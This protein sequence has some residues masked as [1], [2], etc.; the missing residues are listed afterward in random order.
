MSYAKKISNGKYHKEKPRLGLANSSVIMA[1]L[2]CIAVFRNR[3]LDQVNNVILCVVLL[4]I[5]YFLLSSGATF[6]MRAYYIKKYNL[7]DT[8][9]V[10]KPKK[11]SEWYR[12]WK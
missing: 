8:V 1:A 11:K 2:F 4:G 10:E 12:E 7:Q 3:I 9:I 5:G 6:F